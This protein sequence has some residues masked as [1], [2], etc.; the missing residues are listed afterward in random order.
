MAESQFVMMK[1]GTEHYGA[2]ILQVMSVERML[3][4]SPV[5]GTISYI[6]GVVNLRGT[7]TP[8]IDLRERVGLSSQR[9]TSDDSQRIV[10]VD[11]AGTTVGMI[12]DAVEDVCTVDESAI[13]PTPSVVGGL[14]AVYLQGIAHV[15]ERLLVL[16]NLEKILSDVELEQLQEVEKHV[17]G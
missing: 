8:V 3:D 10:V 6:K 15:G 7:I 4:I 17:K 5:P 14:Q 2:N 11:V 16:L 13:E 9:Q 12:V 1:I